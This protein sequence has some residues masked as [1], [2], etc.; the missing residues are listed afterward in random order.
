MNNYKRLLHFLKGKFRYLIISLIMILIIQCLN[1]VSPLIVK[2]LLDDYI[3]GIEYNWVEVETKDD[4]TVD[5]LNRLFK[6]ER[7]IDNDDIVIKNVSIFL[8]ESKVYFVDEKIETGQKEII[9]NKL[10]IT[11]NDQSY[12]YDILV[13]SSDEIY[14]FYNPMLY[15]IILIIIILF[16][17]SVLTIAC[18]FLQQMCTNRIVNRIVMEERLKGMKAIERLPISEFEQEPAGKTAN[19]IT[20]DVNGILTMYRQILN[21][22]FSAILSFVFAYV[23]MFYLDTKLALLTLLFY[24]FVFIWV[25]LFLKLLNKIAEKVN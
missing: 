10:I 25:K 12:S 21:L 24:P 1:F 6:Q 20:N 2:T 8:Y 19:R 18:N 4:Y 3:M 13:L 9:N 15:S 22:F 17:K 23:G 7:Y 14:N 5:Y 11:N 16:I